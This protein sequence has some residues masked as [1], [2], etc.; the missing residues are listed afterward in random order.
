MNPPGSFY[1][2]PLKNQLYGQPKLLSQA[3]YIPAFRVQSLYLFTTQMLKGGD[4]KVI[5]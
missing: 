1:S 5:E 3:K 2:P 4:C